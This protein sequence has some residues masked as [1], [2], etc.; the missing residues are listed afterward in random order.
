MTTTYTMH[1]D[2]LECKANTQHAEIH[3]NDC[4]IITSAM[5]TYTANDGINTASLAIRTPLY[6]D[7]AYNEVE[8]NN[9]PYLTLSEANVISMI[10]STLGNNQ[11]LVYQ[12]QLDTN[13]LSANS[14]SPALPWV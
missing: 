9:E 14:I 8:S 13:L 6:V 2:S 10:Q 3:P 12:S 5:W 7:I 1:I 4:D 11:L